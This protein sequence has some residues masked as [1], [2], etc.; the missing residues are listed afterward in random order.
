MRQEY[1]TYPFTPARCKER[2]TRER[3]G[4]GEGWTFVPRTGGFVKSTPCPVP[5]VLQK[6]YD[7]QNDHTR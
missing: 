6:T 3:L 7:Q 1:A 5:E 2:E 4:L